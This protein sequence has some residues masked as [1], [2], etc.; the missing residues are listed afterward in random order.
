MDRRYADS[1]DHFEVLNIF[2]ILKSSWKVLF[3][4]EIDSVGSS[5]GKLENDPAARRLLTQWLVQM[6]E[7]RKDD[8]FV[9]IA[10]TN[11]P[12]DLDPAV[13][14]RFDV[15]V[16][17]PLPDAEERLELLHHYMSDVE[18]HLSNEEMTILA[19]K[20]ASCSRSDLAHIVRE[21]AMRPLRELKMTPEILQNVHSVAPILRP[22]VAQDFISCSHWSGE[23]DT[24]RLACGG[25]VN[26]PPTVADNSILPAGSPWGTSR[27]A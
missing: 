8:N 19:Q 16:E 9:V 22:I 5:R 10:A 4:D 23:N 25:I 24:V 14:R 21:V 12:E 20:T 11:R 18:H 13:L 15:W 7:M 2:D 6:N 17:V 1:K 26:D 3:F 27:V